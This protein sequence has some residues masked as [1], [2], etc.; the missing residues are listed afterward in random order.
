MIE[1]QELENEC[2]ED[3]AK[4]EEDECVK[5]TFNGWNQ[6]WGNNEIDFESKVVLD[7]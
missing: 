2:E 3:E 6:W 1:E 4:N 7:D 5:L